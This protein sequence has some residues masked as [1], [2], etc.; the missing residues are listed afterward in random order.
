MST[1][2][3]EKLIKLFKK[4]EKKSIPGTAYFD[5]LCD[6]ASDCFAMIKK[7]GETNITVGSLHSY[8]A[9]AYRVGFNRAN[10]SSLK[11]IK[12]LEKENLA[13]EEKLEKLKEKL[14]K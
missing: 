2:H 5:A 8:I 1:P 13:L 7:K 4:Y 10:E 9:A 3:E 14:K 11:R 6:F 12:E